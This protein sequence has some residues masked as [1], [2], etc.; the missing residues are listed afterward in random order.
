M[1]SNNNYQRMQVQG[2]SNLNGVLW[3]LAG[4]GLFSFIYVSGKLSG[5]GASALQIMW[6]RYVGG[7][8]T[9]ALALL[10]QRDIARALSTTQPVLH[11]CRA[12]AGGI[13]GVAAI[14]AAAHMPVASAS[15]IGLLDGLFTVLL[16]VIILRE[17]VSPRQWMGTI[18]SLTGA[19]TVVG[20]Q[21]AFSVWGTDS[22]GPALIALLGA[23]LVALESILIKTLVRAESTFTVLFYVNFFGSLILAWPGL[24]NWHG[25][26]IQWL[27][28]FLIL[29]PVAI[30]AQYCN[31]NAFRRA[32]ASVVGPIRYSWVVYGAAFGMLFFNEPISLATGIG[33][34]L[35]L[36]G[37]GWLATSKV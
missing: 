14:F 6:L 19:M 7:F 20:S 35:V 30:L 22:A 2:A 5:T 27:L 11:A 33:I 3:A 32:S 1:P 26:P 36:V 4:M 9:M 17:H 18:V 23:L 10:T 37:G 24:A 13:G 25:I 28:A 21:G 34:A 12:A 31:I 8:A 29:G 16:G 15:A